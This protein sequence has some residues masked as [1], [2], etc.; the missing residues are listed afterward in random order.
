MFPILRPR[1]FEA[2]WTR[3]KEWHAEKDAL[4]KTTVEANREGSD[5][6]SALHR[7]A[8]KLEAVAAKTEYDWLC[9]QADQATFSSDPKLAAKLAKKAIALDPDRPSAHQG[10][11]EA[12]ATSGDDLRACECFNSAAERWEPES[13]D[14]AVAMAQ[15]LGARCP[16]APCGTN[17]IFCDC[18][19]CVALPEK[20]AWMRSPQSVV[21]MAERAVAAAPDNKM[22]WRMLAFAHWGFDWSTASKHFTKAGKL[23][24]YDSFQKEKMLTNALLCNA[25][26]E[27]V[28][29]TA[30]EA[31]AARMAPIMAAREAAANAAAEALL[32]EE[33]QEKAVAAAKPRKG[34]GKGK[35]RK[36]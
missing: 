36:N 26:A 6:F 2:H 22:T 34:K 35:G 16:A 25:F 4:M 30:A 31:E 24:G 12:F 19:R 32:A 9:C 21:A 5:S 3:H 13:E 33:E 7:K 29:K 20:L 10:L 23:Y 28:A 18:E 11:G 14:W 15:A 8:S 17:Y 1:L 27:V